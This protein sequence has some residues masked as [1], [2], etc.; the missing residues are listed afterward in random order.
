VIAFIGNLS[1]LEMALIAT[2]AIMVFGRNLP[3]VAA[4]A[5][6]RFQEARRALTTV[7]R[8]S[9]IGEEIRQVQ[10][11]LEH[12]KTEF[13]KVD[14]SRIA[15]DAMRD[16]E[17]KARR[18]WEEDPEQTTEDPA[19]APVDAVATDEAAAPPDSNEEG[20][21]EDTTEEPSEEANRRPP[22]YP[23]MNQDPFNSPAE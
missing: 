5:Y 19:A 17:A 4:Q 20:G 22:W 2:V 11:E 10:R 1:F 8:E 3:R 6:T 9:G 16:V 13:G 18:P 7:W 21:E 23:D 15:R 12:T 14:P